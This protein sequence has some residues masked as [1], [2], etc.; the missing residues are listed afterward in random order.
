M[1]TYILSNIDV[2]VTGADPGDDFTKSLVRDGAIAATLDVSVGFGATDISYAYTRFNQP[3]NEGTDGDFSVFVKVIFPSEYV[4]LA[5]NVARV[6]S[7]GMEWDA[8]SFTDSQILSAA[9]TYE[10][11]QNTAFTDWNPGDR[12]RVGF[13]FHNS[14]EEEEQIVTIQVGGYGNSYVE[15]PWDLSGKW[16][17]RGASID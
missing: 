1:T 8:T 12:L 4:D 14:N 9:I 15:T 7:T 13:K 17:R 3:G 5:I 6:D 10:F 11:N 2:T 16:Q